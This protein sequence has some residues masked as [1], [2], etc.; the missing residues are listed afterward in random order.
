MDSLNLN[1]FVVVTDMFRIN[2]TV[3]HAAASVTRAVGRGLTPTQG[4]FGGEK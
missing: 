1:V 4:K 2:R 3:F